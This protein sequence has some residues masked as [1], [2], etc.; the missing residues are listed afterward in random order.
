MTTISLTGLGYFA[1]AMAPLIIIM[2][3]GLLAGG[4]E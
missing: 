4:G 3:V 2:V 1:L